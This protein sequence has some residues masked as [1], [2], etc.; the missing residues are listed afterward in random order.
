MRGLNHTSV[1][2]SRP[3]V[4]SGFGTFWHVT[5]WHVNEFQPE[6]PDPCDMCRSTLGPSSTCAERV[7]PFGHPSCDP[8][9]EGWRAAL[10]F[11]RSAQPS[12]DFVVAGG[13]W[14]GHIAERHSGPRA[15]ASAAVL[16]A[17][18]LSVAFPDTPTLHTLGNHD[19]WPYYSLAP[20]WRDL[21]SAWERGL[22]DAYVARTFPAEAREQWLAGGYYALRL[23]PK[24]W[25]VSL[26]TNELAKTDGR[27]QLDWLERLLVQA[28]GAG[29]AAV[30]VGHIPPGPSHF[31]LDSI[32]ARGHYYDRAGGACWHPASRRRLSRLLAAYADVAPSSVW[33]HHHTHSVRVVRE[34][35]VPAHTLY[36]SPALTPRN[37]THDPAIRLFAYDRATGAVVN[38]TDW[39]FDLAESN[40]A[41]AR[42][43]AP[44]SDPAALGIAPLSAGAWDR[45]ATAALAFDHSPRS[46]AELSAQP[47]L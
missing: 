34:G 25:G 11:M 5:D 21:A 16:L 20:A 6:S 37:P 27:A 23:R 31:E 15:V 45:W 42:A 14:L 1:E 46:S 8:D 22:G 4:A 41:R 29:E 43:W 26:N 40:A 19:T 36:L 2:G 33:G 18:M 13:D 30:L 17:R 9:V 7:G 47:S 35:G 10:S 3:E 44:R 28:R 38:Y 32:C 39:T 12:P 24:L